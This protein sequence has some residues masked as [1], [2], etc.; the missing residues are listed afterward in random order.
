MNSGAKEKSRGKGGKR[1]NFGRGR[2]RK[3]KEEEMSLCVKG[4]YLSTSFGVSFHGSMIQLCKT[5]ASQS[6]YLHES[7]INLALP[8]VKVVW[9]GKSTVWIDHRGK[10]CGGNAKL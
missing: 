9:V 1:E 10:I 5:E 8:N 7:Y 6:Y 2:G 3:R 4:C